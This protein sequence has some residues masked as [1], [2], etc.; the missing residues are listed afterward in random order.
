MFQNMNCQMPMNNMGNMFFP[1]NMNNMNFQN[2]GFGVVQ[3]MLFCGGPNMGNNLNVPGMNIG[4]NQNWMQGYSVNNG[5]QNNNNSKVDDGDKIN[6]IFNTSTGKNLNILISKEK[7]VHD[8]IKI[9]FMR[10]EKPELIN[11]EGDICFVFNASK[12]NF[13][14]HQKIKD[15]FK[16]SPNPKI[17]VNDLQDLIGA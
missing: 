17:L 14:N 15:F 12:I 9:Y 13:N 4:G 3:P 16:F 7:T 6:C 1:N 10:V 2:N 11:R 8:L 5:N